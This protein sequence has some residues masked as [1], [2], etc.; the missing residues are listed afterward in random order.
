MQQAI[1][2]MLAAQMQ[3][4]P[5]LVSLEPKMRQFFAK[6][7]SWEALKDDYVV[8]YTQTFTEQEIRQLSAFYKT[9]VGRKSLEKMPMLMQKGAE[10][11]ADR[12]RKNMPELMQLLGATPGPAPASN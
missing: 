4:N 12:V 11:G 10:I 2:T 3:A 8:L 7:M 5:Q 9:P 6:H 1:D